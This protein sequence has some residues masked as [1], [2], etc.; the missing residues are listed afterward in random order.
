M[1]VEYLYSVMQDQK[2][3]VFSFFVRLILRVISVFYGFFLNL[4]KFGYRIGILKAFKA[5]AIVISIGNITLG[6]TG[7]TP[8]TIYLADLIKR[9]N[10]R[11]AIITRG[12][13]EDE[14]FILQEETGLPVFIGPNKS[15]NAKLISEAKIAELILLDDGFQHWKLKRDLDIVLIDALN[16]FGNSFLFPRGVLREPKDSLKRADIIVFTKCDFPKA[17]PEALK[18]DIKEI[19][20]KAIFAESYYKIESILDPSM[21]VELKDEFLKG[22]D[23]IL[24]SGIANPEYFRLM[25]EK[26]GGVIKDDIRFMDHH[27]YS[28]KDL[29]QILVSAKINNAAV[30]TTQKDFVKIKKLNN[31]DSMNIKIFVLKINIEIKEGKDALLSRLD[32]LIYSANI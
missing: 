12:Y 22:K 19:N 18:R 32:S 30:L 13:G 4:I 1:I 16:S 5:D 29:K 28:D 7:K 17:D 14:K 25:V 27:N 24:V 8:F 15:Q 10:R 6:G 2:K 11:G 21:G 9:Q 23:F 26:S 31:I 3:G 20:D